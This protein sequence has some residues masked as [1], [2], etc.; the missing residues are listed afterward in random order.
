LDAIR[1][2]LFPDVAKLYR[3]IKDDVIRVLVPYEP[4]LFEQLRDEIQNTERFTP[5]FL[6]NWIRR[7]SP[8]AVN[9]FRPKD[10]DAIAP[11]LEPVQFSH[12]R[13]TE[14]READWFIALPSVQYDS[15]LG[16]SAEVEKQWIV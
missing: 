3:I 4:N 15:L 10:T 14:P 12:R 6:R 1:G 7:A 2:G 8:Y 13:K 16:I 11:Y 9:L 5:D